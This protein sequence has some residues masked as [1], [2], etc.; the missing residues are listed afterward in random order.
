MCAVSLSVVLGDG[1][2]AMMWMDSWAPV[3]PLCLYVPDLF[4]A[5]SRI[6]KQFAVK[7]ALEHNQWARDVMG[8]LTMQVLCQYHIV[9]GLMRQVA[10]DLLL[11]NR[12]VW[13][14]SPDGKYS[15]SSTYRAFFAGS[16]S[17]LGANELWKTKAPPRVKFFF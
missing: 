3:G 1:G 6:G 17:L 2:S 7:D 11:S 14:W 10:L 16:T 8:V 13:K 4:V 15:A 12:F 9:W 5:I